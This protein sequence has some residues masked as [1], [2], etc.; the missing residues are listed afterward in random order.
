M[1]NYRL[2]RTLAG[3][4]LVLTDRSYDPC[5]AETVQLLEELQSDPLYVR[6]TQNQ[7]CFRA[8]LTPK[9]WR[10]RCAKP[11]ATYPWTSVEKEQA[12]RAWEQ[13]YAECARG[14]AT[15]ELLHQAGR[16][17]EETIARVLKVH[18]HHACG[19]AGLPLA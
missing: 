19:A 2:Y 6:L 11:P 14:Y 10:C 13:T 16:P 3:L 8:R 9:P 15:C 12:Q 7:E 4:R 1:R 18:D 17:G 5:A